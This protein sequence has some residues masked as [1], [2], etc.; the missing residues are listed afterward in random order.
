MKFEYTITTDEESVVRQLSETNALINGSFDGANLVTQTP[1]DNEV[2]DALRLVPRK[3]AADFYSLHY[4]READWIKHNPNGFEN[5][6][7]S[8][9]EVAGGLNELEKLSVAPSRFSVTGKTFKDFTE[10][11][12]DLTVIVDYS[13]QVTQSECW[14][15]QAL[16]KNPLAP[17]YEINNL[18]V[19]NW[20]GLKGA[21]DK[22]DVSVNNITNPI[23]EG[24]HS[25][26]HELES[27]VAMKL[28]FQYSQGKAIE[29]PSKNND[30]SPFLN[31][32]HLT[33]LTDQYIKYQN[34]ATRAGEDVTFEDFR[35]HL[36]DKLEPI[37]DLA[38]KEQVTRLMEREG[39][40]DIDDNNLDYLTDASTKLYQ[41]LNP[42]NVLMGL[43]YHLKQIRAAYEK[44]HV[45]D[46]E[47]LE[48]QLNLLMSDKGQEKEY[49]KWIAEQLQTTLQNTKAFI[50]GTEGYEP[51]KLV[52]GKLTFDRGQLEAKNYEADTMVAA[53]VQISNQSADKVLEN[54]ESDITTPSSHVSQA[55]ADLIKN[56]TNT[57]I[58]ISET[59]NADIEDSKRNLY[60][61]VA[62][63]L[64]G[65][66]MKLSDEF[67]KDVKESI[68]VL[69]QD[70]KNCPMPNPSASATQLLSLH[71]V[72]A[73]VI[74][75][76]GDENQK[77]DQMILIERLKSNGFNGE[78][79][80][81]DPL[82][83]GTKAD[84]VHSVLKSNDELKSL[85]GER[86]VS[87]EDPYLR[88]HEAVRIIDTIQSKNP[89]L[90]IVAHSSTDT[91]PDVMNAVAEKRNISGLAS[92]GVM[93]LNLS[94]ADSQKESTL[95]G[96]IA[97]ESVHLGL[98]KMMNV[99]EHASLMEK[100]WESIPESQLN[101]IIENYSAYN[102]EK[103]NDRRI[104]AE[105]WLASRAESIHQDVTPLIQETIGS[106][107]KAF[108]AKILDGFKAKDD[109]SRFDVVIKQAIQQAGAYNEIVD[110]KRENGMHIKNVRSFA[111]NNLGTDP[112][113]EFKEQQL[114]GDH[115]AAVRLA[116]KQ[117]FI[118][119]YEADGATRYIA[120]DFVADNK[121]VIEG[122][123]LN[124]PEQ[125]TLEQC[126]EVLNDAITTDP[127]TSNDM[128]HKKVSSPMEVKEMLGNIEHQ[129]RLKHSSQ[130]SM[131]AG[132]FQPKESK[133]PTTNQNNPDNSVDF[134]SR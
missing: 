50:L 101:K 42:G 7:I 5:T 74:P 56:F 126:L 112:L 52:S 85:K 53:L 96:V 131:V 62:D 63:H 51:M 36:G 98:R 88:E 90:Q 115:N 73:I 91:F 61:L 107:I 69:A 55:Y 86:R 70:F 2:V 93:H 92:D 77:L 14:T 87:N 128:Q 67:S 22:L 123:K 57:A 82:E 31:N 26:L 4:L 47:A 27:N 103:T 76:V 12:Q 94:H 34:A 124:L 17:K 105:E 89:Y 39:I 127:T 99:A 43:E 49:Q 68:S 11:N 119:Q 71:D 79:K 133:E 97:H 83:K 118:Y 104:L 29:I 120:V 32:A 45:P 84:A 95:R 109:I 48:V 59:S 113:R 10:H 100:V 16:A 58:S 3:N 108:Q 117:N 35:S 30:G 54:I 60:M 20:P 33:E 110:G 81:F 121:P 6:E 72:K 64:S 114:N 37:V 134:M 1:I 38:V 102:P 78:V 9:I 65:A 15:A 8:T 122:S 132:I 18:S 46:K 13:K 130:D 44:R 21:L 24:G 19:L 106:K 28:A 111:H 41:Q 125:Y 23:R 66:E 129:V 75:D 40:A 80:V 116:S 25:S